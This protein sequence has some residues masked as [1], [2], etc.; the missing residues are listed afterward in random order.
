MF[1]GVPWPARIFSG[2]VRAAPESRL[3]A[4]EITVPDLQEKSPI[5]ILF[6]IRVGPVQDFDAVFREQELQ[7]TVNS[8]LQRDSMGEILGRGHN[9]GRGRQNPGVD[10]DDPEF[11]SG[12]APD[13]FLQSIRLKLDFAQPF[14]IDQALEAEK[15][16]FEAFSHLGLIVIGQVEIESRALDVHGAE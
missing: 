12:A 6:E 5:T 4:V 13:L 2:F 10:V 9:Q 3:E 14:R 15:E 16:P 8:A 7:V 11:L 1:R